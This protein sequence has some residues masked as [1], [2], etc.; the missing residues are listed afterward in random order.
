MYVCMYVKFFVDLDGR[1][2]LFFEAQPQFR[3]VVGY[4]EE[5]PRRGSAQGELGVGETELPSR[6]RSPR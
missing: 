3:E 2:N 4:V 5:Q 1:L 6:V